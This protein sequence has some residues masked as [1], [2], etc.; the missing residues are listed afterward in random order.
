MTETQIQTEAVNVVRLSAGS[1]RKAAAL[2]NYGNIL[3]MLVPLPLGI[4]W[5]A[6]SMVVYA[7]NRHH[8]DPK[9]GHYTQYA[10]YRLYGVVGFIVVVATFFGTNIWYWLITWAISA[11]ILI[12]WSIVDLIRIRKDQWQDVS[13]EEGNYEHPD[14]KCE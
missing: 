14:T 5:I 9:V 7:M 13:Y 6:M 3:A 2:F 10:A 4:L 1:C 8:P 11:A 12:P